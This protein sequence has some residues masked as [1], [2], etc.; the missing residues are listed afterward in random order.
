MPPFIVLGGVQNSVFRVIY[1]D[2]LSDYY[3]TVMEFE[4]DCDG[5]WI[6]RRVS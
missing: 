1:K 3:G 2:W 6:E 4:G 5:T